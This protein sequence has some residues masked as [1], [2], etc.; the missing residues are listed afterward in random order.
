MEPSS[1]ATKQVAAFIRRTGSFLEAAIYRLAM[2]L[3]QWWPH[4]LHPTPYIPPL[5]VQGNNHYKYM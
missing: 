2:W 5:P 1:L 3:P 4:P